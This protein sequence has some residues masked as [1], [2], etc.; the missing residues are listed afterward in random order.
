M[1]I[2][3]N[4][5]VTLQLVIDVYGFLVMGIWVL[6]DSHVMHWV[7]PDGCHLEDRIDYNNLIFL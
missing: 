4:N 7:L 3:L 2:W 1:F 6:D 5:Y